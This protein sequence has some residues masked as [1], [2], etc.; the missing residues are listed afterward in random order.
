MHRPRHLDYPQGITA[1]DAEYC[2]HGVAAIH[3][4]VERGRA[5]FVDTGTTHSLPLVLALLA[6]KGLSAEAVDYV[7]VTHV[8]LDHAGGAGAMMKT[9]PNARLVAHPRGAR[10]MIDPSKLV[11]GTTAVYGEAK[12]RALYGELVPVPAERVVEAG[13]GHRIEWGA[14]RFRFLD[15]PGHASHH[16]CLWDE[17][18]RHLFSGDTFGLS[19]RL[20]D[21]AQGPFLIPTTTPVQFDPVAL[22]AS[23]ERLIALAPKT[24]FLTHFGGITPSR[25]LAD[26]LHR[27]LDA[28]LALARAADGRADRHEAMVDAMS[29]Y[30]CDEL[31]RHGAPVDEPTARAWLRNDVELNVQGLEIWLDRSRTAG[32]S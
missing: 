8:H 15:T 13:E 32:N 16:Y 1:L 22:H 18:H 5:A 28:Y 10:H 17:T 4:I 25:A 11:A 2:S 31:R 19:Y 29:D 21:S 9:F 23:V 20:F 14:R 3:L 26:D 7:M 12:T 27:R 6:E 30:L 24:V